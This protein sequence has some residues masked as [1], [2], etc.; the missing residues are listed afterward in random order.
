MQAQD[1]LSRAPISA[2]N[3]TL[4]DVRTT[5]RATEP[6]GHRC[7]D[8]IAALNTVS[9]VLG[10]DLDQIPAE[11]TLLRRRL[12]EAN[13][14]AHRI[15]AGRWN[16]VRSLLRQ[17]LTRLVPLSPSRSVTTLAPAWQTLLSG[18]DQIA[19]DPRRHGELIR[20]MRF[21]TAQRIAPDQVDQ[22]VFERF[23][24]FLASGLRRRPEQAYS[25]LCRLWNK[26][27]A[28][29]RGWPAFRVVR[30]SRRP[31]WTLSWSA[32]PATLQAD[33]RAWFERLAGQDPLADGPLRPARPLTLRTQ[34]YQ[35]RAAVAALVQ[36][37]WAPAS[38]VS[39]ADLVD[40]A[41]FKQILRSLLSRPRRDPATTGQVG[42]IARLLQAIARHHVHAPPATLEAMAAIIR[43]LAPPR[44]GMTQ[45]NRNRLRPLD[46]P[47]QVQAL[48]QLPARLMREAQKAKRPK[49]RRQSAPAQPTR[50]AALLAQVAVAIEFL[51][52]APLRIGNLTGLDLARHV[53]RTRNTRRVSLVIEDHEVKNHE[54]LDFPLPEETVEL[55]DTYL[56]DFRPVLAAPGSTALFPGQEGQ[57]KVAALLGAQISRAV[58]CYT[59]LIVHA[60][61]FRHIGAKIYL[62][63][64]PGGYEVV[65]RV[66]GQRSME[67]TTAFYTGLE[68]AA[69]VRHFDETIL[70]VRRKADGA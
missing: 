50:Q 69:A 53:I 62:D 44:R 46:D 20:F 4:A 52:M 60:H 47:A 15:T 66:L 1:T 38:I 64:H 16:N 61:L 63:H 55:L 25:D 29:I 40:L 22:A 8:I 23:E 12:A 24:V 13:P 59:G 58:R 19:L 31:R 9:R 42:D 11:P 35:L 34:D 51:L 27:A 30:P 33:V 32:C 41:N 48:L 7:Q 37:G 6:P 5:V 18:L 17:A 3:P 65:R 54:P 14:L 28:Q 45:R 67:T 21:C 70:R 49:P 10:R 36:T 43:R 26:M 57:P 68:T 39:L 2:G 56:R